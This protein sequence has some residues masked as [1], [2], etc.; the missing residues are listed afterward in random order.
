MGKLRSPYLVGHSSCKSSAALS[1]IGVCSI[2]CVQ[3][4]LCL[5]V[6]G[7]FNMHADV[8]ACNCTWGLYGHCDRVSS[9]S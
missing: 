7:I 3:T 4:V 2:S 9:E 8:D 1:F 5:P 6:F